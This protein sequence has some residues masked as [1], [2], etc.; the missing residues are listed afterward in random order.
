MRERSATAVTTGVCCFARD[1]AR[2]PPEL[3]QGW[4]DAIDEYFACR[5]MKQAMTS[6]SEPLARPFAGGSGLPG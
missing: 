4:E 5:T 6:R 2:C 1:V 3:R